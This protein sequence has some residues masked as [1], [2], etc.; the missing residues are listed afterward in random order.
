MKPKGGFM[1]NRTL[2]VSFSILILMVAS[3]GLAN[4][5]SSTQYGIKAEDYVDERFSDE[6]LRNLDLSAEDYKRVL[7]IKR[8]IENR[9]AKM[10]VPRVTYNVSADPYIQYYSK[11]IDRVLSQYESGWLTVNESQKLAMKYLKGFFRWISKDPAANQKPAVA[12]P[13]GIRG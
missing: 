12:V 13:L 2:N 4:G 6:N 3:V 9:I 11:Q 7:D 8:F 5:L 1:M 10:A